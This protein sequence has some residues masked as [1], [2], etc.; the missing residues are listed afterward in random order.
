M[1]VPASTSSIGRPP[2]TNRPISSSGRCVAESPIRWI[3]SS[4]SRSQPLDRERQVR[5][6]LRAGDGVHLVEDQ[7]LDAAQRLARRAR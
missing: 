6:A 5:A 4:T 7:R 1:R 3:G 2:E